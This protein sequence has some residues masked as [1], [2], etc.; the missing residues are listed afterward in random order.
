MKTY[1]FYDK[2]RQFISLTFSPQH[3]C[4]DAKHVLIWAYA[5]ESQEQI[6]LTKHEKRGWELPGGKVEPGERP[7]AAAV[8]ELFEETGA[9]AGELYQ[10]GQYVIRPEGGAAAIVKNIYTT[11]VKAWSDIPSGFE[12]TERRVVSSDITTFKE[13]FSSLIQDNVFPLCRQ[14]AKK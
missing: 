9:H 7:E 4:S 14:A 2:R 10:I 3:F 11:T 1:Y 6:V 8:R 12:T 13:G 5:D